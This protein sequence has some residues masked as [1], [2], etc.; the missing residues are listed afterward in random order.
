EKE[1]WVKPRLLECDKFVAGRLDADSSRRLFNMSPGTF[2]WLCSELA[3]LVHKSDTNFRSSIPPRK[4]IAIAIH[5]L[6]AGSSYVEVSKM[7]AVGE[8]TVLTCTREVYAAL[9]TA[10]GSVLAFPTDAAALTRVARGFHNLM[11]LPN[12]C[13]LLT[14]LHLRIRRPSG[15][16]GSNYLDHNT[17]FSIAA[18]LVVDASMRILNIAVGFPGGVHHAK[19]LKQSGL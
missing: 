7:F 16:C 19:I 17:N 15:P 12:C 2:E 1:W 14:V 9:S 4:R 10:F 13:G 11:A 8:A 6:A 18:Q 5:R 3:P